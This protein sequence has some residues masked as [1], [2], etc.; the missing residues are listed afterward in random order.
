MLGSCLDLTVEEN[1]GH[2]KYGNGKAK[3]DKWI[4]IFRSRGER[5]WEARVPKRHGRRHKLI[6][7]VC[8]LAEVCPNN[9]IIAE[10]ISSTSLVKIHTCARACNC[11]RNHIHRIH[12][13]E[14]VSAATRRTCQWNCQKVRMCF[15]RVNER[16]LFRPVRCDP[17]IFDGANP[18]CRVLANRRV[19]RTKRYPSKTSTNFSRSEWLIDHG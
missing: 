10:I 3:S 8:H 16:A 13:A 4:F 5:R 14:T 7:S 17:F 1:I 11:I 18:T 19:R 2:P 9:R 6:E 15:G 12:K